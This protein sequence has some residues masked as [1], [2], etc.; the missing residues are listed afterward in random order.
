MQSL[1]PGTVRALLN[2]PSVTPATRRALLQR[3]EAAP[4]APRFF[5][6]SEFTLLQSVCARLIPQPERENPIDIAASIDQR[7]SAGKTDG[8]RYEAL[9]PDGEAYRAGLRGLDESALAEAGQPFQRLS[10]SDQD[11][12]LR[13]VQRGEAPGAGWKHLPA[14]RFFE[15]LLVEAV[16]VYFSH[17]SAQEEIGYVGF[18]DAAGGQRVGFD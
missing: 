5:T 17:P 16:E 1:L 11:A 2:G 7:L 8:W 4:S 9:P 12:L 13:A 14:A 18:A 3:L 10:D 6:E 15:E